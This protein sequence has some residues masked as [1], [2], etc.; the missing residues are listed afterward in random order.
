[1]SRNS[2]GRNDPCP[3]GSGRKYKKCCI[4]KEITW[5]SDESGNV[6][7]RVPMSDGLAN[8]LSA[9]MERLKGYYGRELQDDDLLFP[10]TQLEH[11]E[12]HMSQAMQR[13]GIDP[14]L[15]YAF[16]QTG[17]MVSEENQDSLS[18]DDLAAWY[19]AIEEFRNA[20]GQSTQEY[21]LGTLAFYGPDETTATKLVASVF[22][23][24][25]SDP[26]QK[27]FF[28]P[29]VAADPLVA[30]QIVDWFREQDVKKTVATE[31]NIG[32]PHEEGIDYPLGD[33]CPKCPYWQDKSEF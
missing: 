31:G 30:Q 7:R 10:D 14:A 27:K 8:E 20:G 13:A 28:G 25:Q 15:I 24:E 3:C 1:M 23:D 11:V 6:S 17:L 22:I 9:H 16:E 12:H 2:I 26:I 33:V 32:C 29:N 18:D 5:E 4:D 19:G 21:P